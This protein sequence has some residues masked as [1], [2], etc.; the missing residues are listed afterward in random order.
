[1]ARQITWTITAQKERREILEYG[2]SI[3]N[4]KYTAENLTNS[5]LLHFVIL[6][7]ILS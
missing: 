1:M 7:K 6:A 3:I 2:L 4:Q 5:L